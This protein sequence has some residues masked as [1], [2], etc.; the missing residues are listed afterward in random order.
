MT[1]D[2]TLQLEP[3]STR[4]RLWLLALVVL[5][6][7]AIIAF[8]VGTTLGGGAAEADGGAALSRALLTVG[9]V[10]LLAVVVALVIDRFLHRHRLA[11]DDAGLEVATSFYRRRLAL[12][13][14]DLEH[15]RVLDLG[16]R[17]EFRPMLKTNG[18]SLPG[19]QS[20]WFR[21]R[22]RRRALVARAGGNRV[23]WIPTTR[24]FGL[25]LQPKQPRVVLDRLRELAAAR[26]GG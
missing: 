19:F 5:L 20:G 1:K 16:E 12:S 15:A 22:D 3:V 2:P 18:T 21:L 8:M 25:L 26:G 17:P 24:G 7:V 14:L 11:L 4:T 9:G 6:P 13:E 10:A 23:L